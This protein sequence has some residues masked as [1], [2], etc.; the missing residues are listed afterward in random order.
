MIY[1]NLIPPE[2]I[3][4]IKRRLVTAAFEQ[5]LTAIALVLIVNAGL[6][7]VARTI[8][9]N[10]M[11][12][13]AAARA[14]LEEQ[15]R[16]LNRE[17]DATNRDLAAL[18]RLTEKYR[19]LAPLYYT[20]L[21]SI[22]PG[23]TISALGVDYLNNKIRLQGRADSREGLLAFQKKLEQ[24]PQFSDVK[25]PLSQIAQKNNV[26]FELSLGIAK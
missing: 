6:L 26:P 3:K 5:A 15:Y 20:I 1:L 19:P 16:D 4:K 14:G 18:A 25:I 12:N 17:V 13:L 23:I 8:A 24:N 11:E 22:P 21:E 10:T 9:A 7:A 2:Q